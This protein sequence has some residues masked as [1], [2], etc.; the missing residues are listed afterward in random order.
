LVKGI[1]DQFDVRYGNPLS[2]PAVLQITVDEGGGTGQVTLQNLQAQQF[3]VQ[4]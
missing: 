1:F 2:S 3:Q 4:R